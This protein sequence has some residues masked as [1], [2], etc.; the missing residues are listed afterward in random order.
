MKPLKPWLLL[1]ITTAVCLLATGCE[2][3]HDD[4]DD[5]DHRHVSTTTTVEERRVAAPVH[6][7]TR[8][9]RSY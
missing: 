6:Q 4:D 8:V 5:D 3:G 7:E 1:S 9:I 2:T